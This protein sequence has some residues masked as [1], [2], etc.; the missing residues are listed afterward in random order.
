MGPFQFHD[1][2]VKR[3]SNA[4][5]KKGSLWSRQI[6]IKQ[7][8]PK[9]KVEDTVEDDGF[10]EARKENNNYGSE[11]V[12]NERKGGGN[13]KNDESDGE[14]DAGDD[15]ENLD[16][17]AELWLSVRRGGSDKVVR[18]LNAKRYVMDIA[19]LTG[20]ETTGSVIIQMRPDWARI[21]AEHFE[22]LVQNGVYD[23]CRFF[24]VFL[25]FIVQFGIP[26][27][28][29][30]QKEWSEDVLQDEP[31]LH[32]NR[33]GTMTFASAGPNTRTTQVFINLD[34][35]TFLDKE[36]FAPFAEVVSGMEY[37]YLINNEYRERPDQYE[38]QY[39]GNAYL[40]QYYPNLSYVVTIYEELQIK[41]GD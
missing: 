41:V 18:E 6:K 37:L 23:Q 26:A 38:I 14:Y 16:S 21:G 34:D 9:E 40:D 2:K 15:K 32:S 4:S 22:E 8:T 29:E 3:S 36:V 11:A 1:A 28:P 10:E 35:N 31:V 39:K 25:D 20:N 7:S 12:G 33:R 27:D 24:R 30:V 17:V 5:S 13:D 19:G